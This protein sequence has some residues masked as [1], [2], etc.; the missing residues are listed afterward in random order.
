MQ[1]LIFGYYADFGFTAVYD[2]RSFIYGFTAVHGYVAVSCRPNHG[3]Y[4]RG[5]ALGRTDTRRHNET[6]FFKTIYRFIKNGKDNNEIKFCQLAASLQL[7]G[8]C[9]FGWIYHSYSAFCQITLVLAN[10]SKIS[11]CCL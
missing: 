9:P 1:W 3:G 11:C 7:Y 5:R 10:N 4:I 8:Y 6:V 2:L